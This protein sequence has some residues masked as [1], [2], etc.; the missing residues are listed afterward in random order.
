[1]FILSGTL[2][3]AIEFMKGSKPKLLITNV[4]IPGQ[5]D[6]LALT[7]YTI[8]NYPEV[9]VIVVNGQGDETTAIESFRRGAGDYVKK[10]I[11]RRNCFSPR[12]DFFRVEK[13]MTR[14]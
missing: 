14:Q 7:A 3:T 4:Q 13:R 11:F 10:E 2:K 8:K 1:M 5:Q 6:G 12:P 9:P